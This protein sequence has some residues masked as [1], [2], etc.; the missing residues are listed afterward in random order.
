MP[1]GVTTWENVFEVAK[2]LH[3]RLEQEINIST[4][5]RE[6]GNLESNRSNRAADAYGI[7]EADARAAISLMKSKIAE[8]TMDN[9]RLRRELKKS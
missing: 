5:L 8:L 2:R 1:E 3:V 7:V 4:I 6:F 9:D